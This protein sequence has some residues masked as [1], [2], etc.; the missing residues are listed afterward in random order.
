VRS[1]EK[2]PEELSVAQFIDLANEMTPGSADN[3][4]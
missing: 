4:P 2:R 1:L 3:Q